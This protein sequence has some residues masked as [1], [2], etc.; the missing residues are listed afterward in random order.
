MSILSRLLND[1]VRQPKFETKSKKEL[2]FSE[3]QKNILH[4]GCGH[5]HPDKLPQREFPAAEWNEIRLDIDPNVQPNVVAS[6]TDMRV[7]PE[8]SFDALYS[9][10]NLEHLYAHEIHVALEEFLRVLKPGGQLMI[11]VPD[12]QSVAEWV[13]ADRIDEMAYMSPL[14]P[15]TPHD[16]MFGFGAAIAGG[17][18][19]MAHRSAFTANKLRRRLLDAGFVDIDV[20]RRAQQFELRA[21]ASKRQPA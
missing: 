19:F 1:I 16:M 3:H 18:H 21:I 9:S 10:H 7:I 15:I 14:G 5:Y 13:A 17:N 6:I 4:V 12:I 8:D 2:G 11:L 20:E